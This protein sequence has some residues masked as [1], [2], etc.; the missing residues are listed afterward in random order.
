MSESSKTQNIDLLVGMVES[1]RE[2]IDHVQEQ[3]TDH[4]SHAQGFRERL[5]ER[6]ANTN[7]ILSEIR[8]EFQNSQSRLKSDIVNVKAKIAEFEKVKI[9]DDAEKKGAWKVITAASSVGALGGGSM[10]AALLKAWNHF[11][12]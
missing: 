6:T 11:T 7:K 2:K 8:E 5:E 1:L 10:V 9:A 3:Q 12:H 4:F